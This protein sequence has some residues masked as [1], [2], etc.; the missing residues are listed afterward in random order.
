MKQL[1]Y[2]WIGGGKAAVKVPMAAS[3]T[4]KDQSGKFVYMDDGGAKLCVDT[5]AYI[6]GHLE[7]GTENGEITPS[8]GDYLNCIVDVTAKFRIPVNSG[9]YVVGML[10]DK[11]DIAI[12]TNVQGAQLDASAEDLLFVVGGDADDNNYVDVMIN[13]GA[14]AS[15]DGG[16][17][18]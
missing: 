5:N 15:A 1:K 9:I 10:G 6:F 18:D 2:G 17:E 11:C 16:V 4:I 12:S 3:Q 14:L 13:P 7:V 8:A